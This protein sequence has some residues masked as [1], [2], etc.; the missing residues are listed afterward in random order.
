[1]VYLWNDTKMIHSDHRI[2]KI[3]LALPEMG[4]DFKASVPK[5]IQRFYLWMWKKTLELPKARWRLLSD[6]WRIR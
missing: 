2:S 6:L 1:M 4:L 5:M 3:F